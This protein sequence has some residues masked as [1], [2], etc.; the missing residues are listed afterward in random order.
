M[1]DWE[2]D[3]VR[4]LTEETT[5]PAMESNWRSLYHRLQMVRY[6]RLLLR[7]QIGSALLFFLLL[8]AGTWLYRLNA[9]NKDLADRLA[10][11]E[12]VVRRAEPPALPSLTPTIQ[13]AK[14]LWRLWPLFL[15]KPCGQSDSST[16]AV[17][18]NDN[19]A[20]AEASAEPT[21]PSPAEGQAP[22]MALSPIPTPESCVH[23][24]HTPFRPEWPVP[25]PHRRADRL[26][27][28]V[29]GTAGVPIPRPGISWLQ[30][31]GVGVEF[32][33]IGQLW[34][35][36]SADWLSYDVQHGEYLPAA[37][38]REKPPQAFKIVLGKPP[39]PYPLST[40]V[41]NQRLQLLSAGVRYRLP[42]RAFVRPSLYAAHSWARVSPAIY[43]YTFADTLPG[44]SS[45][46]AISVSQ[47]TTAYSVQ[48]LWRLG[49]GLD[50]ET[51][52]WVVRLSLSRQEVFRSDFYDA[53]LV[54]GGFWYKW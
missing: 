44:T 19:P 35:S 29:Q 30:G 3:L 54:Q 17:P 49:I 18:A 12:R 32:R 1:Y 9:V 46:L 14:P 53:W 22:P 50:R 39:A 36:A 24:L 42:V 51:D 13:A 34:V 2:K 5:F 37:F 38:Y 45:K 10:A 47:S 15:P 41:G 20:A 40:V 33:T 27:I 11:A 31:A 25:P 26:W 16:V 23:R 43:N 6:R 8:A 52:R 48:G 28:G 4:R 7:W 21:V